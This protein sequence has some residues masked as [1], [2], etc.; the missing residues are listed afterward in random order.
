M[1][2]ATPPPPEWMQRPEGGGRFA[3]WLIR[4][5]ALKVGRTTT[6]LIL[7]P[8][9]AYYV[10]RRGPERRASRRFLTLALG[11]PANLWDVF[12]H[13]HV[14]AAVTLDRIFLL[15]EAFRRFEVSAHGLEDLH[16]ALDLREGALLVGVHLGSFDALRVL[17]LQRPEQA[18]RPV[19]DLE[20]NPTVSQLLNA[21][22]PQIAASIINA[23]QDGMSTA[24]AIHEAL[25]E[26]ALVTLLA[27]RARPGNPTVTVDFLGEPAPFPAS[28]WLLAAALKVPV[29]L[30]FGLYRGGRRYELYFEAFADRVE[31]PHRGRQEALQAVV[32]RFAARIGHHV[33]LAPRNWF[34]FYDFWA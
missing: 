5:L 25:K 22:N 18:V 8:V 30:C 3:L 19:I 20:Q 7:V 1:S 9:A 10:V 12:R 24:L 13:M 34:N 28:P 29:V 4:F 15:T 32:A 16:R 31:L 6:R 23:R 17:A 21:L 11:R 27:D 14:F 26:R 2:T 33:K